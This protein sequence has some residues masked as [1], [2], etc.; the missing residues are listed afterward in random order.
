MSDYLI[1]LATPAKAKGPEPDLYRKVLE[2]MLMLPEEA[3]AVRLERLGVDLATAQAEFARAI[4]GARGT[5]LGDIE[6]RVEGTSLLLMR[7]VAT[8]APSVKFF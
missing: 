1:P 3:A 2:E 6:V 8:T 5:P 4:E 7:S